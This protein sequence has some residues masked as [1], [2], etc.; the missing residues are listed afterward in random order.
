MCKFPVGSKVRCI[1]QAGVLVKG[2]IYTVIRNDGSFT[3]VDTGLHPQANGYFHYRFEAVPEPE[4]NISTATD[5]ELADEY[6][7]F[8]LEA[9]PLRQELLNRGFTFTHK[10]DGKILVFCE[11]EDT[12]ISKKEIIAL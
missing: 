6:R 5:Q 9:R 12:V 8:I 3:Y 7:R 4:F 2:K 10:K 11:T 1:Q